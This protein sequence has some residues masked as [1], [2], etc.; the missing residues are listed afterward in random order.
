MPNKRSL[1]RT[2][3]FKQRRNEKLY[4]TEAVEDEKGKEILGFKPVNRMRRI[5][6]LGFEQARKRFLL[7]IRFKKRME[8]KMYKSMFSK[9]ERVNRFG[10][11][12]T[13]KYL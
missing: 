11:P 7:L 5:E 13:R 3:T 10:L 6:F 9:R 12:L 4:G 2:E 8:P 1:T